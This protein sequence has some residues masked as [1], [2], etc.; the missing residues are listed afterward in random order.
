MPISKPANVQTVLGRSDSN[1]LT[2]IKL[3]SH[4]EEVQHEDAAE[5][6][7]PSDRGI[8]GL[9]DEILL[10]IFTIIAT[11]S[12]PDFDGHV[13]DR[14][15]CIALSATCHR[16]NRLITSLLYRGLSI[17]YYISDS[18]AIRRATRYLHRTL[19]ENPSLRSN[20]HYLS[21]HIGYRSNNTI[22]F[23]YLLDLVAWLTNTKRLSLRGRFKADNENL[24]LFKAAVRHMPML[25]EFSFSLNLDLRQIHE[26]IV[27]LSHLRI[28]EISGIPILNDMLPRDAFKKSTSSITSLAVRGF[29][30]SSSVLRRLV[31]W[32]AKLESFSFT[33]CVGITPHTWSL[34]TIAS[35]LSPHKAT[36]RSITIGALQ[37]RGLVD[38]DLTDFESLENLSLSA[39]ATGFV[40]GYETNL[41]SPRL[42]NFRWSFTAEDEWGP[43]LRDFGEEQE[44]WLKQLATA[45]IVRKLPLQGIYIQYTPDVFGSEIPEIYPWDRMEHIS[46]DIQNDGISL[47]WTNPNLSRED[48]QGFKDLFM[49][50]EYGD[51]IDT[52]DTDD[53]EGENEFDASGASGESGNDHNDLPAQSNTLTNYFTRLH[54]EPA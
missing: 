24:L 27:A 33:G 14:P 53:G 3:P 16:F 36:L 31:A 42:T 44:H 29:G 12:H 49:S 19:T 46:R 9:P 17:S 15:S 39:W 10:Q 1:Y 43:F 34:S 22:I 26:E 47:S 30:D 50:R 25:E 4:S 45:A 54:R 51:D 28:L 37:E 38:F 48:F 5:R 21:I 52:G 40:A 35:I 7:L 23:P 2:I 32:P 8:L 20:C 11:R 6:P 13:N 18:L 41:L